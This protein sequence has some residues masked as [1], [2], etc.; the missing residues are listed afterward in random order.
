MIITVDEAQRRLAEIIAQVE[1][2]EEV[3]I[4]RDADRPAVKLVPIDSVRTR[5]TRHPDLIGSTV[6]HDP[7]ALIQ[8]LPSDEWGKLGD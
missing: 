1:A 7:E 5:L 4:G 2:G 8:P 6:T 3:L